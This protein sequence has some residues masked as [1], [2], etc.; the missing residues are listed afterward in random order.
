MH[1]EFDAQSQELAALSRGPRPGI[2]IIE[3][4]P[5]QP[6]EEI[7][8]LREGLSPL[9]TME[10]RATY[11]ELAGAPR[12]ITIPEGK[13]VIR[14]GRVP[15][16][17][18]F[19]LP[20]PGMEQRG[21]VLEILNLTERTHLVKPS[22]CG[23]GSHGHIPIMRPPPDAPGSDRRLFNG[24]AD[25]LALVGLGSNVKLHALETG[26]WVVTGG[27]KIELR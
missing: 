8:G 21:G 2:K 22:D 7:P 19:E 12:R 5:T 14:P 16:E 11:V 3:L 6:P 20:R 10:A 25:T 13:I 4:N 17:C 24:V 15:C 23:F 26:I 1:T 27:Y 9:P 18:I